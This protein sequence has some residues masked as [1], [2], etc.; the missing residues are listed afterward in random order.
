MGGKLSRKNAASGKSS[1]TVA[2]TKERPLKG[3]Q[4]E[5]LEGASGDDGGRGRADDNGN[6]NGFDAGRRMTLT[7]VGDEGDSGVVETGSDFGEELTPVTSFGV[8]GGGGGEGGEEDIS[9]TKKSGGYGG[10]GGKKEAKKQNSWK[11][12]KKSEISLK[13]VEDSDFKEEVKIVEEPVP[14]GIV[15]IDTLVARMHNFVRYSDQVQCI[16]HWYI[17]HGLST[18]KKIFSFDEWTMV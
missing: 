5:F 10:K 13:S 14:K 3:D 7:H 4:K 8:G 2:P 12:K 11:E 9:S 18:E 1:A 6:K 15:S 16:S 17:S